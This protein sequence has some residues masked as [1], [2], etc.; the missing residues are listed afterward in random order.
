MAFS[1]SSALAGTKYDSL[2][3]TV[4][5]RCPA[6]PEGSSIKI[7]GHRSLK[8]KSPWTVGAL[9]TTIDEPGRQQG[10]VDVAS[11]RPRHQYGHRVVRPEGQQRTFPADIS[12]DPL[13]GAV[14]AMASD[15]RP[16]E[17]G[18]AR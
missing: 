11:P 18:V 16:G 3:P 1:A 4:S 10:R 7:S 15:R 17:D 8:G 12:G 9:V 14:L 2:V 13:A 5:G 6:S